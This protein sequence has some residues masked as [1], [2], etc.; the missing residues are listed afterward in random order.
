MTRVD[1]TGQLHAPTELGRALPAVDALP[2]RGVH[3]E[4][5]SGHLHADV[6]SVVSGDVELHP[7]DAPPGLRTRRVPR[8]T[9]VLVHALPARVEQ[10][11]FPARHVDLGETGSR[12]RRRR[13]S[14]RR[15]R[16]SGA[17]EPLATALRSVARRRLRAH[18]EGLA[19]HLR[20][21]VPL[22]EDGGG[23]GVHLTLHQA[24]VRVVVVA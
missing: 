11:V 24:V 20:V 4:P 23:L 9:K 2:L 12:V 1:V 10:R 5:T 17:R 18:S 15:A 19:L 14:L 22:A 8:Q 16:A 6:A 13:I 21:G 3:D 7:E